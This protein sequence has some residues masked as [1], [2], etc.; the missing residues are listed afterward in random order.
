MCKAKTNPDVFLVTGDSL[1]RTA[2]PAVNV[3]L[4]GL[5]PYRT[6]LSGVLD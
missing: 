6:G 5:D 3:A 1:Q 2:Q 4:P